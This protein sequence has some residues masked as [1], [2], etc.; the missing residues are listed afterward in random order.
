MF[1]KIGNVVFARSE[2]AQY[3]IT[4]YAGGSIGIRGRVQSA[5]DLKQTEEDLYKLREGHIEEIEILTDDGT[6]LKGPYKINELNWKK[7]RKNDGTYE[8]LFNVGLQKQ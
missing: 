7:E 2:E 6:T 8:L 3:T 4:S 5:K 1:V